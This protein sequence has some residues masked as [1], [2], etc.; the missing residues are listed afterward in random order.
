MEVISIRI[1]DEFDGD[2]FWR[3]ASP[4]ET[5]TLVPW[6]NEQAEDMT[7]NAREAEADRKAEAQAGAAEAR[8]EWKLMDEEPG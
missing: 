1:E 5:I 3:I 8:E 7:Q 4:L 2:K 6:V